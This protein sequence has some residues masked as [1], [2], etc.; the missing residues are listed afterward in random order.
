MPLAAN[1]IEAAGFAYENLFTWWGLGGGQLK[2]RLSSFLFQINPDFPEEIPNN[3]PVSN[4]FPLLKAL[5][6]TMP[7]PRPDLD[8]FNQAVQYVY[9]I[10]WATSAMQTAGLITNAQATEVLNSYN[11]VFVP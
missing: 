8:G 7:S 3:H 10:C 11:G 9:R 6:E 1:L 4:W 5:T 2:V